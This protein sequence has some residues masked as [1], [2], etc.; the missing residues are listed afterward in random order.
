MRRTEPVK[1][2]LFGAGTRGELDLGYFFLKYHKK[3]KYW[4]V[5][6]P[7]PIRRNEFIEKFGTQDDVV[8][9]I[10]DYEQRKH[11]KYKEPV[12]G[13]GFR[14]LFR[15]NGFEVY[16]V[17]E[18]KTSCRCSICEGVCETFRD[19]KNPKPWKDN[20]ITRHGLTMCKTCKVKFG[21]LC[22]RYAHSWDWWRANC[23]R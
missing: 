3:I 1:F 6:E 21:C 5:A 22:K 2:A 16:L 12:K 10:G 17:D 9:T 13:K 20:I 11:M 15:K 4:A 8:I 18:H 7:D 19:C 23:S 14:D